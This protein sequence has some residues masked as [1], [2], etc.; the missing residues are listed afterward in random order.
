MA[1]LNLE[2]VDDSGDPFSKLAL[3]LFF[4]RGGKLDAG[5]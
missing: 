3:T 5:A 2:S 1:K 4:G